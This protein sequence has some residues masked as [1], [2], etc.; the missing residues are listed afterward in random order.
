MSD[1]ITTCSEAVG[2]FASPLWLAPDHMHLCVES[3][4][5]TS[6]DS[7]AKKLKQLSEKKIYCHRDCCNIQ[8]PLAV[9]TSNTAPDESP[10]KPPT[11]GA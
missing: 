3:D 1:A 2:G 11:S 7:M 8:P 4:G 5:E 9:V 10:V 6:P